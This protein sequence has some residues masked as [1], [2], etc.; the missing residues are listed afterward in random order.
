MDTKIIKR[1]KERDAYFT[2]IWSGLKKAEKYDIKGSVPAEAGVFELYY[3]DG[4]KR[5]NLMYISRVWFGGLRSTIRQLTDP[6][7]EFDPKWKD[8]LNRFDCYYRYTLSTSSRD[9]QDV[10][11]YF[12]EVLFPGAEKCLD[13]GRYDSIYL[14]EDSPENFDTV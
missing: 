5:L 1:L 2:V 3:M 4:K 10:L 11:F 13:S 9:M 12:S 7:L 8:I 6:D 14:I